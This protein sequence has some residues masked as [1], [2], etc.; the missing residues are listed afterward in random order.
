MA[1]VL[2]LVCCALTAL[3]VWIAW[4]S[5]VIKKAIKQTKPWGPDCLAISVST[6]VYRISS[7]YLTFTHNGEEV[8]DQGVF[9]KDQQYVAVWHPHGAYAIAA[10]C[11]VSHFWATGYPG[12]KRGDRYVCVAPLLFRIPLLAE[13]LLLC[14]ARSQ[15]IKTFNALL[16]SGAT[17]G[18]QPGGIFEQVASDDKEEKVFFPARLGFVRLALQHGLPIL[19]IYAF[20]E[21]Q[22]Y[23]M[24]SF[25]KMINTWLYRNF[26][27][28]T[29]CVSGQFGLP[30]PVFRRSLHIR[31]G[32]AVS[33]GKCGEANPVESQVQEAFEKYLVALNKL[34]DAHKDTCLPPEVA[35]RGLKVVV[36]NAR[37]SSAE[38]GNPRTFAK[39]GLS[40]WCHPVR[41]L[42][43][44]GLRGFGLAA[45]S[46]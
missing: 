9:T 2:Q 8:L 34:F 11:F 38:R 32:E 3:A 5:L 16:S 1:G 29:L 30:L 19:P 7:W 35:A 15:D 22:L 23:T 40:S 4:Y 21:N 17:V 45:L 28:G 14:G 27:I 39:G 42:K 24:T 33:L 25:A 12:G 13:Y 6:L 26:K 36:R 18:V 37:A 10:L 41:L 46:T 44:F 31:F 43:S 20:G